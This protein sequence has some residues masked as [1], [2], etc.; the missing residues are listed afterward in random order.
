ML[1]RCPP[2]ALQSASALSSRAPWCSDQLAC[3]DA[4]TPCAERHT[5]AVVFDGKLALAKSMPACAASPEARQKAWSL[6][7]RV[8]R[9][10]VVSVVTPSATSVDHQS[11]AL[12]DGERPEACP[13]EGSCS[14]VAHQR[15]GTIRLELA[16]DI[17]RAELRPGSGVRE[18]QP[19]LA[20]R[21]AP[22]LG[23]SQSR[24]A[25]TMACTGPQSC[26]R[27]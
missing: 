16:L 26:R 22:G 14:E 11:L 7:S 2:M 9:K 3:A 13:G 10:T 17:Q 6:P 19:P 23:R 12:V 5:W 25:L 24:D 4:R 1:E 15:I 18:P 20:C 8:S 21:S 27:P